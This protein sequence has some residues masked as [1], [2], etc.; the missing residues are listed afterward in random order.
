LKMDSIMT[1]SVLGG[2]TK[3]IFQYDNND[4]VTEWV[5]YLEDNFDNWENYYKHDYV[6]DSTANLITDFLLDWSGSEW[7]SSSRTDYYYRDGQLSGYIT[8]NNF[9]ET[10]WENFTRNTIKYNTTG[11][12]KS[13]LMEEY[14]NDRWE[15]K[16][17]LSY[18][19][20]CTNRNTLLQTW[21]NN[22]WQD[23]LNND[24]F[25]NGQGDLDS[26]VTRKWDGNLWV[27]FLKLEVT[28]D[29]NHNQIE[30]IEKEWFDNN[31][32]NSFKYNYAYN[33]Q[34]YIDSARS[35]MWYVNQWMDYDGFIFIK[36]PDGYITNF[37]TNTV[38]VY[39]ERP[40]KIESIQL[41]Q[42]GDFVLYQNYP[43]PFN[44]ATIITYQLTINNFVSLKVYNSLG[45]E[46]A[47]LVNEEKPAGFYEVEFNGTGMASGVY[48]YKIKTN[49]FSEIRKMMLV[50]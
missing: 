24:F 49:E 34:H 2:S 21:V 37:W 45:E 5:C 12:I 28:N 4:K 44:P 47:T 39:Y 23:S 25:Y 30:Q 32:Q 40:T 50:K 43:N 6:Y 16:F 36:N 17:L 20:S 14:I 48:F 19:Y 31:W 46:V 42:P 33:E 27:N 41:T 7:D 35:L 3:N 18:F 26:V 38:S 8:Q 13:D 29:Q 10:G 1:T 22:T 11:D 9:T 15:Y